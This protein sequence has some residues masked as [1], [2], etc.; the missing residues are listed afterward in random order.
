MS[1][2]YVFII[3]TNQYAG[4]FERDMCA[5]CTGQIGDCG[6]GEEGKDDFLDKV[7]Q[8][9]FELMDKLVE[10]NP[11]EHGTCRPCAI[12][13][14][15][16]FFNN[17]LGGEFKDGQEKDALIA[18]NAYCDEQTSDLDFYKEITQEP[19]TKHPAYLSVAIYFRA[20]PSQEVIDMIKERAQKFTEGTDR[21]FH[22]PRTM[23]ITGF[24]MRK[25][26]TTTKDVEI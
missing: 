25:L 20:K 11:D 6:V 9:M 5:F 8:D 22:K 4:N 10:H 15:P 18:R 23:K 24:R 14:T 26:T 17:G 13:P 3:D 12:E 7:G 16:G 2:S 21:I 1:E 19:L